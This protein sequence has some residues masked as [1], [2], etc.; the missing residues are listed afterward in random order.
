LQS[1]T[2]ITGLPVATVVEFRVRSTT[3]SG[4]GDWGLL[5]SLLVM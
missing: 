1:K 2:T 4:Q 3:K 5:T